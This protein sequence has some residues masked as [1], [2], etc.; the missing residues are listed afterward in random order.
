MRESDLKDRVRGFIL[1][2]FMFGAAPDEL[3][4]DYSL[5][6]SGV[7]DS[8]GILELIIH[9]EESY[10]IAIAADESVPDNLDSVNRI[11]AFLTRKGVAI[12]P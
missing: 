12:A 6:D 5:L 7:V 2:N 11:M 3:G 9:L 10:A 1:E 4:D 8:T